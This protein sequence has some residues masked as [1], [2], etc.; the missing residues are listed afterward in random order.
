MGHIINKWQGWGFP[1][2]IHLAPEPVYFMMAFN[3]GDFPG[4]SVVKNLPAKQEMQVWP[5]C[6][7][8]P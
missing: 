3:V 1:I 2:H 7:E 5:L 4:G 6:R 8:E